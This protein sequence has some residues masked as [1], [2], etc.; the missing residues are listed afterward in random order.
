MALAGLTDNFNCDIPRIL[1]PVHIVART[2]YVTRQGGGLHCRE[3]PRLCQ[4]L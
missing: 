2:D 1:L 4:Y 3:L